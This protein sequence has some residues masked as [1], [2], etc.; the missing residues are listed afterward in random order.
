MNA[1]LLRWLA[2]L[3]AVVLA[4]C[5]VP[6]QQMNVTVGSAQRASADILAKADIFA[7]D[8]PTVGKLK[9]QVVA[10]TTQLPAGF[11][12]STEPYVYLVGPQDELRVTIFEHPELTNPSGIANELV[13]RVVNSDG[14]FFFP[15]IGSVQ[16]AGRSVQ[17]IQQTLSQGLRSIL[18][19][20]Q[21]DVAVFRFRSQRVVV[22][23][24][25]TRPQTV[26]I[27]DVAPTLAEVISQAGGLTNEADLANV[28]VTRG[29]STTRVDMYPYYYQG[30][31]EQNFVLQHGDVV[32][33]PERRYNKVF[34]LGEVGRPN[35]VVA[36]SGAV[37]GGA[38]S[39]L[40]PR[41]RYSLTEA[42]ADVGGVNPL[43][44]NAGQIY[45]IRQGDTKAQI[46][47]LDASNPSALLL[48]EQFD[49]RSRDV[50]YVDAVPVVRWARVV[51]NILPTA[52]FLRQT[53]ND[54]T[55]GL[56]R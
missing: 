2:V 27:T 6:G 45:V 35:T 3:A 38:S 4:G 44:G 30:A 18:K 41:G 22:S 17:D 46:Y 42:L 37:T 56:P 7:I 34:V 15:Y 20:P 1:L 16:A 52:D 51:N 26:P 13:G 53:L 5:A 14:K 11:K 24:E 39:L 19:N 40:M 49:L 9:Q 29:S 48:A 21:V 43:S 10:R 55:R 8:A 50:I 28:T 54:T 23:G 33:V 36:T 31:V 32:N 25:V 12:P 47:H